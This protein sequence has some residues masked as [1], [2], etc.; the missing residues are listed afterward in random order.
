[1]HILGEVS[2][3]STLLGEH[4]GSNTTTERRHVS[5]LLVLHLWRVCHFSTVLFSHADKWHSTAIFLTLMFPSSML[6]NGTLPPHSLQR[7]FRLSCWQG[8]LFRIIFSPSPPRYQKPSFLLNYF[9]VAQ[10][11]LHCCDT[12]VV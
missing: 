12:V 2:V 7:Y 6:T 5:P 11:F 4:I 3:I 1:M 8:F 9:F 10:V